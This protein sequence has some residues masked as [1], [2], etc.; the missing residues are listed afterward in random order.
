M[1]CRE[2][3]SRIS[4]VLHRRTD[5]LSA[6]AL[7]HIKHCSMCNAEYNAVQKIMQSYEV[8]DSEF[9]ERPLDMKQ[10]QKQVLA[11]A[12]L[13]SGSRKLT[14]RIAGTPSMAIGIVCAAA[15]FAFLTLF[16]FRYDRTVGYEVAVAGVDCNFTEC[17]NVICE[18]LYQIGLE[19]ADVDFLGCNPTCSLTVIDLKT[20][21]E[22]ELVVAAL[23][24]VSPD[25]IKSNVVPI[26]TTTEA[27][28][29]DK[30]HEKILK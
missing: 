30:A 8:A 1:R 10:V 22:A 16:P 24:R 28:L 7:S 23:N 21:E 12:Q 26:R 17:D 13:D 3:K 20:K 19:D 14:K 4:D 9:S 2:V 25:P 18:L 5:S 11:R 29:L 15:V 27:T 6:D